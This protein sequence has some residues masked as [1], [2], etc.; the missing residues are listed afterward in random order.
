VVNIH[1]VAEWKVPSEIWGLAGGGRGPGY[2]VLGGGE[3]EY[4]PIFSLAALDI[5]DYPCPDVGSV[6]SGA[7]MMHVGSEFAR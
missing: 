2:S 1:R 7:T 4:G 5:D 6:G 3:G